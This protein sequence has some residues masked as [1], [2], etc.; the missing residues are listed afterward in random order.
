MPAFVLICLVLSSTTKTTGSLPLSET[1]MA[2]SFFLRVIYL[3]NKH[4]LYHFSKTTSDIRYPQLPLKR[5][6]KEIPLYQSYKKTVLGA[7]IDV[8]TC[9]N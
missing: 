5:G 3:I 1:A 9:P 2:M 7:S 8:S 4:I 6:T